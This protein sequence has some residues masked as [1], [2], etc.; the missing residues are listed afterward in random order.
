[1]VNIKE[2]CVTMFFFI[3]LIL[4]LEIGCGKKE[5]FRT[6]SWQEKYGLQP[7]TGILTGQISVERDWK[8]QDVIIFL[9]DSINGKLVEF[10]TLNSKGYF[11]LKNLKKGRYILS[12]NELASFKRNVIPQRPFGRCSFAGSNY[13][14]YYLDITPGFIEYITATVPGGYTDEMA[15]PFFYKDTCEIPHSREELNENNYLI[16]H[17]NKKE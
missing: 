1:M 2:E 13:H 15:P 7:N 6:I 10:D 16:I 14:Y 4:I 12:A 9:K 3:I 5:I 11:I 17:N 8:G